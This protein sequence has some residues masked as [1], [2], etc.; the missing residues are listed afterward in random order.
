[1]KAS[2]KQLDSLDY[3]SPWQRHLDAKHSQTT[4]SPNGIDV[5]AE[6]EECQLC[7]MLPNL[8]NGNPYPITIYRYP[9]MKGSAQ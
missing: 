9:L 3:R 6:C 4:V 1:M 8:L 2:Q 5:F 7:F